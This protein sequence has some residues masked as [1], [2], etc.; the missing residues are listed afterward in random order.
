MRAESTL[1]RA[2]A[3]LCVAA[4][5]V[6]TNASASDSKAGARRVEL[7]ADFAYPNG[8]AV[9]SKDG[10]VF[11]GSIVSGRIIKSRAG[12]GWGTLFPG[13][14]EIFAGTTLRL[15]EQRGLLW[16]TSPDFLGLISTDEHVKPRPARIFAINVHT[17]APV[18]VIPMPDGGVGND[19]A[20]DPGGG[21]YV[22]DSR[23]PRI[24]Y[25]PPGTDRFEIFLEDER[26]RAGGGLGLAGVAL[27]SDGALAVG[28]FDSGRLFLIA[29]NT[30]G[31]PTLTEITLPRRLENPDGMRFAP[32]G[33]HL[34]LVEGAIQSGDGRL[35]S[36]DTRTLAIS[37]RI[38]TIAAG[39]E[40]PVN[41]A[42]AVDG[43]AWVT[44]A[45]IRHRLI[46]G[47][48]REMPDE[49]RISVFAPKARTH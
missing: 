34:L 4:L 22:T 41:L 21:L 24:L 7:P 43:A 40:S 10:A 26:L 8:I 45:R 38:Q 12:G 48:A 28:M 32:D 15:D 2:F 27:A 1:R 9:A 36:I 20:I 42:L 5:F 39:L 14:A 18:K 13:S 31:P 23:N 3:L 47:G 37:D 29:R 35:I 33:R 44:E 49:F 19:I 16:G 25:L 6:V 46:P 11:V 30:D 17:G